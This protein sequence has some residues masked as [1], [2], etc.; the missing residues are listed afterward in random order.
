MLGDSD[1]TAIGSDLAPPEVRAKIGRYKLLGKEVIKII[2]HS[3][4]REFPGYGHAPQIEDPALFHKAL[5]DELP[6]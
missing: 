3:R 1:T 4:L 5:L 2:P 6:I